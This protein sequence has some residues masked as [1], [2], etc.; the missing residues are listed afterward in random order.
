MT[1]SAA[2]RIVLSV[3]V[4]HKGRQEARTDGGVE[5]SFVQNLDDRLLLLIRC[6]VHLE[7][8]ADKELA[9]HLGRVGERMGGR[10]VVGGEDE[11]GE[12]MA[13]SGELCPSSIVRRARPRGGAGQV[14]SIR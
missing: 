12:R 4:K 3:C 1:T 6:R 11:G 9:R 2:A 8:A 7:V 10:K 13:E 14:R 5:L